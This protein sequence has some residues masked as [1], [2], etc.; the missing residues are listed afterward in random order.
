L[1][2]ASVV[3]APPDPGHTMWL[4]DVALTWIDSDFALS[5]AKPMLQPLGSVVVAGRVTAK[6][7]VVL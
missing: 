7:E 2:S 3:A 6:P 1:A 5:V 4:P